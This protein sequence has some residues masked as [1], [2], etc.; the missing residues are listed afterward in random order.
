MGALDTSALPSKNMAKIIEW[1]ETQARNNQDLINNTVFCK[2]MKLGRHAGKLGDFNTFGCFSYSKLEGGATGIF[3]WMKH[4][5]SGVE[6]LLDEIAPKNGW[7]IESNWCEWTAVMKGTKGVHSILAMFQDAT[8]GYEEKFVIPM[9]HF[10]TEVKGAAGTADAS[11]LA[12]AIQDAPGEVAGKAH[13]RRLGR[14]SSVASSVHSLPD[15][16]GSAMV[17]TASS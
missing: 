11:G 17:A 3:K 8:V 14:Q 15:G 2:N 10:Y 5:K 7:T 16:S 1:S 13:G 12:S 9:P 6:V 4:N